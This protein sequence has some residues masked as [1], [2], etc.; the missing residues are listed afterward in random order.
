MKRRA[1]IFGTAVVAGLAKAGLAA[2]PAPRIVMFGDSLTEGFGLR[3]RDNLVTQS[4]N[5]LAAR[6]I[7]ARLVN[8][9]LTGDT[10]YGGRIR[11]TWALRGGADGVVVELG[12]NDV[13]MGFPLAGIEQ[14][15]DAILSRAGTNGRPVLLVGLAP[16]ESRTKTDRKAIVALWQRLAERHGAILLPDL[17]APIWRSSPRAQRELLQQDGLHMSAKGVAVVVEEAMGP[18]LA[19]LIGKVRARTD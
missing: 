15:L 5:W 12:A 16:P 11:I 17:Y 2:A 7:P 3:P 8:Q 14:N 18:K 13:L 4:Q 9:G 10:T 19:E 6:D 1:F